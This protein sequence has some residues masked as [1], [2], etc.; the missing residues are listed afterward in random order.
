MNLRVITSSETFDILDMHH[1]DSRLMKGRLVMT[2]HFDK[3]D[4]VT[5][6]WVKMDND[7]SAARGTFRQTAVHRQMIWLPE[8]ASAVNP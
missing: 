5:A 2:V 8:A 1:D 6:T 7:A 3:G 4:E